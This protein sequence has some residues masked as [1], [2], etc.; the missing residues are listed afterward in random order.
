MH[1]VGDNCPQ[2]LNAA[3]HCERVL[4]NV[5][6]C[7]YKLVININKRGYLM[8]EEFVYCHPLKSLKIVFASAVADLL[9]IIS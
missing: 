8:I 3:L 1:T 6:D 4:F 9:N 2:S 7:L 5:S